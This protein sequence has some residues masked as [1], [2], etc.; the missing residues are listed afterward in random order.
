MTK[1]LDYYEFEDEEDRL[2][3]NNFWSNIDKSN[4]ENLLFFK[5]AIKS[6]YIM[7][8]DFLNSTFKENV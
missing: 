4:E 5:N 2:K 1:V 7:K 3:I 6:S 8:K